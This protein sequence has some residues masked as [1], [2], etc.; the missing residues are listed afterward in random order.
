M[1][2]EGPNSKEILV[3]ENL[4]AIFAPVVEGSYRAISLD[5]CCLGRANA[6]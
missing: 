2:L 1:A 4:N 3:D 5:N 6:Q